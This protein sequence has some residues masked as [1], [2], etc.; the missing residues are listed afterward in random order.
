LG[1]ERIINF[2]TSLFSFIDKRG[3]CN[4]SVIIAASFYT[5]ERVLI[6]SAVTINK[7]QPACETGDT[8]ISKT[9]FAQ[10]LRC[11]F[12]DK[13]LLPDVSHQN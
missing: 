10:M 9:V 5:T 12:P 8:L 13:E 6:G 11:A 7:K 3:V 4:D 2:D 1:K